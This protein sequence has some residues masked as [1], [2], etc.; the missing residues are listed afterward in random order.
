MADPLGQI[1]RLKLRAEAQRKP[2]GTPR[3]E[4]R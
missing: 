2:R 3:R 1:M 4:L